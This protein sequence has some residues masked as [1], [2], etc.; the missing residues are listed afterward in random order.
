MHQPPDDAN[1]SQSTEAAA[2]PA[3]VDVHVTRGHAAQPR[4]SITVQQTP[5]LPSTGH[6]WED[7][8]TRYSGSKP[9]RN[10]EMTQAVYFTWHPVNAKHLDA[11]A[12]PHRYVAAFDF[13]A[14]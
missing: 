1:P 14:E 4:L 12:A 6:N 8:T 3:L 13:D 11:Q 9:F 2:R 7:C 10:D 5:A